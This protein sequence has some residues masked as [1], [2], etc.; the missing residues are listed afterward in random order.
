MSLCCQRVSFV[1]LIEPF[2]DVSDPLERTVYRPKRGILRGPCVGLR[3][4]YVGLRGPSADLRWPCVCLRGPYV[5]RARRGI[6]EYNLTVLGVL[7]DVKGFVL[8]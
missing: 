4:H 7:F 2:I 8:V 6:C 5:S 3:G 1:S